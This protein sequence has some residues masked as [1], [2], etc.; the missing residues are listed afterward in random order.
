MAH[1]VY[2]IM[3]YDA[4]YS[5]YSKLIRE[6][7]NSKLKLVAELVACRCSFPKIVG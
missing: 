2:G 3:P 5:R 6:I 7:I 4:S 1:K